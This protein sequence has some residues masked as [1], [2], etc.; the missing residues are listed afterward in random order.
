MDWPM[1]TGFRLR[2]ISLSKA[3]LNALFEAT[4]RKG[5]EGVHALEMDWGAGRMGNRFCQ[6]INALVLCRV[7]NISFLHL[8]D[9]R[10]FFNR[11]FITTQG[12]HV[13]VGRNATV[14]KLR[15][16]FW[17]WEG[18][19]SCPASLVYQAA[20]SIRDEVL[21]YVPKP[22]ISDKT[23][24]MHFRGGDTFAGD[25]IWYQRWYG[26]PPCRFYT[27]AM[28]MD[29]DHDQVL[30]VVEDLSN[31]CIDVCLEHGAVLNPLSPIEIDFA[32][33]LWSRRF[34]PSRSSLM[35]AAMYLSPYP[36]VAYIFGGLNLMDVG[37]DVGWHVWKPFGAH[38]HC[39]P[40]EEYVK[41]VLLDW[42]KSM[43]NRRRLLTDNCT[44]FRAFD[45]QPSMVK[46]IETV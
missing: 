44:W 4:E 11:S 12:V 28:D 13:I 23:L 41:N 19:D 33:M 40:T 7:H 18:L 26:Q 6:L 45:S 37:R 31:P 2:N 5:V 3:C 38:W 17:I 8:P 1:E 39:Q 14:P 9:T 30:L 32:I 42:S 29:K 21:R 35:R 25:L 20:E 10:E 36:K 15:T 43:E 16:L 34:V 46:D 24:V 27:D 22:N